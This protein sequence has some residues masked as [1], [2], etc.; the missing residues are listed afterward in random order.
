MTI[1]SIAPTRFIPFSTADIIAMCRKDHGEQ[2]PPVIDATDF[3]RFAAM[4]GQVF[5][6]EFKRD[7]DN[8]KKTYAEI[9]PDAD[10]REVFTIEQ[11]GEAKFIDLLKSVLNKANYEPISQQELEQAMTRSSLFNLRLKVD[12]DAFSEVLLFCRGQS[13]RQATVKSWFGLRS[14]DVEFINYDRVVVYVRYKSETTNDEKASADVRP[15]ATLLKLFQNVPRADLEMLFPNTRPAMRMQDKLLIGIPALVSGGIVVTT[16]MGATLL[17]MSS[18]LGFWFGLRQEPV[19]L[20]AANLT[21]LCAGLGALGA[22]LWQ[23]FSKFKNRQLLF[24]QQLTQNLYF[25]N[26][27]NNAGVIY[28]LLNDAEDEEVKESVLAYYFLISAGPADKQTLDNT[29]EQWL[30]SQWQCTMD[31]EIDDALHKLTRLGLV[32]QSGSTYSALPLSDA[33]FKLNEAWKNQWGQIV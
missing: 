14:K 32:N 7:Q 27:D 20:N 10:T 25:K 21:I 11:T 15:G 31:F 18:M 28:R 5:H 9:D 2:S 12:F 8:L 17:L 16:K 22:Y 23:Q 29:I 3:E 24:L 6:A 13:V 19:E 33:I 4:V 26:L 1:R 30:A